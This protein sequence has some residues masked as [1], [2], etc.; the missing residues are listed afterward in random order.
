MR[1]AFPSVL[2]VAAACAPCPP[3]EGLDA[4][5][6]CRPL[7]FGDGADDTDP[8]SDDSADAGDDTGTGDDT[9]GGDD[10]DVPPIT[11]L[12]PS[13]GTTVWGD[14]TITN[15]T[16]AEAFCATFDRVYGNLVI[17]G[18]DIDDD[19]VLDCLVEVLGD[20]SVTNTLWTR[21]QLDGL[22]TVAG[23]LR[24]EGVGTIGPFVT[25]GHLESLAG[26]EQ[27]EV[28]G[29]TL[30]L[31]FARPDGAGVAPFTVGSSLARL[32]RVG[33]F[34][35]PVGVEGDGWLPALTTVTG[36]LTL[37]EEGTLASQVTDLR[38]LGALTQVGTLVVQ[39]GSL[40]G[41]TSYA[42]LPATTQLGG[43]VL[44][45]PEPGVSLADLRLAPRLR[46]DLTLGSL[47]PR[48][49][50]GI[51]A[52]TEVGGNLGLSNL[53][54]LE[55][56]SF[57]GA[58]EEVDGSVNLG[59]T[60]S[61]LPWDLAGWRGLRRVGGTLQAGTDSLGV[62]LR[63]LE[64]LTEVG[65]LEVVVSA[66]LP[67]APGL[68]EVGAA[69]IS[70]PVGSPARLTGLTAL[71][72]V[73][74]DLRMAGRTSDALDGILP[75]LEEAGSLG[76]QLYGPSQ[77]TSVVRG[78]GALREAQDLSIYTS[79]S[80]VQLDAFGALEQLRSLQLS[81]GS[82]RP[83]FTGLSLPS[84]TS[85]ETVSLS[86]VRV[87][88]L[89][90]L[91]GLEVRS[92]GLGDVEGLSALPALRLA[93][94]GVLALQELPDLRSTAALVAPSELTLVHLRELDDVDLDGLTGLS[95]ITS[96]L[97]LSN[98]DAPDLAGL[99]DLVYA[100]QI[101]L[102]AVTSLSSLP[103]M[104]LD[105]AGSVSISR[106]SLTS[107]AGL[108]RLA[109]VNS[110]TLSRNDQLERLTG[111]GGLR[112][113]TGTLYVFRN[114]Q[115]VDVGALS[116]LTSVGNVNFTDNTGLGNA[117]AQALVDG[118]GAAVTGSVTISGND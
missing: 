94:R 62:D 50:G 56:G 90:P 42:G 41:P 113:L 38:L 117:T 43:L 103:A 75:A 26:L 32:Q 18:E 55:V 78:L 46:G 35:V 36:R 13:P 104:D 111:L 5:A 61:A 110:L 30:V 60:G 115:L 7:A 57:L 82:A 100:N 101:E 80:R 67:S 47:D 84:L 68:V 116:G 64:A 17:T 66:P 16:V 34:A 6:T 40:P 23:D 105:S 92:L 107:L 106:S 77:Q 21:A 65:R 37:V 114:T 39:P 3:G 12:P 9:D 63:P 96:Q 99:A 54:V 76:L 108:E 69:S 52:V 93:P 44:S 102:N 10:T 112:T 53:A 25:S 83:E 95:R 2:L 74:G 87:A 4:S 24:L 1:A 20:L 88:S 97:Q 48:D 70:T 58:L 29:G 14:L 72:R 19:V 98:L 49:L 91:A 59:S 15:G 118:L 79:G 27:L 28:V 85:L 89:A 11:T 51:G 109:T 73:P 8:G 33:S 81:G 71:R 31:P 45:S 22:R 86:G